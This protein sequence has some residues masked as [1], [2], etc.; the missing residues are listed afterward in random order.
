MIVV[1]EKRTGMYP[2]GLQSVK[3]KIMATF[4]SNQGVREFILKA[5]SEDADDRE[6]EK[7]DLTYLYTRTLAITNSVTSLTFG[8]A[9]LSINRKV[10]KE[11][12]IVRSNFVKQAQKV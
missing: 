12:E 4:G 9:F 7:R 5:I 10:L 1:S 2:L 8:S 6:K 3:G 11:Q